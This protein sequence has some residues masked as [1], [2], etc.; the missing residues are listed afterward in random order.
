MRRTVAPLVRVL[1]DVGKETDS[2]AF[3]PAPAQRKNRSTDLRLTSDN[4]AVGH[5]ADRWVLQGGGLEHG[6]STEV[7]VDCP[8]P[9]SLD[10]N[11]TN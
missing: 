10:G 9:G 11:T 8:H 2:K 6:P 4:D 5:A 1:R 3:A 7:F